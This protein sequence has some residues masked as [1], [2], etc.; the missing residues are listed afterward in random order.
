MMLERPCELVGVPS[1]RSTP[2]QTA[3]P[4][5]LVWSAL[6]EPCH[7]DPIPQTSPG[8]RAATV[9]MLS[10]SPSFPSSL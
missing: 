1:Q 9:V 2:H 8:G 5:P 10:V 6:P 7:H 4:C 3:V